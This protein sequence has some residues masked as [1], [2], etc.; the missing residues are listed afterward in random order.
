MNPTSENT[1]EKQCPK[2]TKG[3]IISLMSAV[4]AEE[5]AAKTRDHQQPKSAKKS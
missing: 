5:T 2:K 1:G 4:N 3:K